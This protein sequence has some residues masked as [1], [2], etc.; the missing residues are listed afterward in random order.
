MRTR[1]IVC[2]ALL[3]LG[4]A[5]FG[6]DGP[7]AKGS[8]LLSGGLSFTMQSGDLYENDDGDAFTTLAFTPG[9]GYF[10]S[11]GLMVG[12]NVNYLK[13]S[14]GDN[15]ASVTSFGPMVTYYFG[16]NNGRTE[17]KGTVYPYLGALAAFGSSDDGDDESD[18]DP[19]ITTFGFKGGIVYMMSNAVGLDAGVHYSSDK[20]SIDDES[21]SGSTIQIAV[22]ITACVF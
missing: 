6:A 3:L 2:C 21:A 20:W 14:Q 8:M 12:A 16:A 10:V 7:V 11:P 9:F 17:F 1:S 19:S 15:S 18:D 4:T 13:M 22:G 5:A